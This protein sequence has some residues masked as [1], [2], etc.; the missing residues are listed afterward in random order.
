MP[1]PIVAALRKAMTDALKD[2]ALL[3]DAAK[4]GLDIDP[5]SGEQTAR[6]MAS[7]YRTPAP[8]VAK[9]MMIMGRK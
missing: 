9:A 5:V 8:V 3:A 6:T 4:A 7:F 2:K 1:Q